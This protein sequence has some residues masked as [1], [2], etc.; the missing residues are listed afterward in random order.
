PSEKL[1]T[2]VKSCTLVGC[3]RGELALP[4]PGRPVG[5]GLP[6][7]DLFHT[8]LD[9]DL[10]APGLPVQCERR[11]R[12]YAQLAALAT[13]RVSEEHQPA[14]VDSLQQDESHRG[15]AAAHC[16]G[17]CHRLVVRN[18]ELPSL[19]EPANEF[20]NRIVAPRRHSRTMMP[21]Q[22]VLKRHLQVKF[23]REIRA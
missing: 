10:P 22:H 5:V 23:A 7:A 19:I 16:R 20:C 11:A 14:L 13:S 6:G 9:A 8:A 15:L 3:A 17:K 12:I 18:S 1:C 2:G 4:R 21:W